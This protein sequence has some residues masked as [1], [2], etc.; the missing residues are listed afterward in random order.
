MNNENIIQTFTEMAPNYEAI[1]NSELTRF[2]GVSYHEFINMLIELTPIWD[3]AKILDIA[4]GTGVIPLKI[5]HKFGSDHE[6]HGLDITHSMLINAHR[7]L[8]KIDSSN[9]IDFTC[10][11][12]MEIPYKQKSFDLVL[13]GLATHHMNVDTLLKE[14]HR[15]LRVGGQLSFADV[16][17]SKL[18]HI[19]GVKLVLGLL[20]Y[21]YY[22]IK[23]GTNRAWA[24]AS[25]VSNVRTEEEWL[26]LLQQHN[27]RNISIKQLKS[28]Y[29]WIPSPLVIF[30]EKLEE[31]N[32][33]K[34]Q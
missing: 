10:A 34:A 13:C 20:A 14:V 3:G 18:W 26:F 33:D 21:F 31:K 27:F 29:F 25:A 5:L 9:S 2:W 17:S 19:P 11:S 7:K 15:I 30:A 32:N 6:I 4:T 12:A 16:G 23:E 8:E 1:V 28:K 24:E 22:M